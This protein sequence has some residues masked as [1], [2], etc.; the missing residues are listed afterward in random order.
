MRGRRYVVTVSGR[1]YAVGMCVTPLVY[2][3]NQEILKRDME[4]CE[5]RQNSKR[6]QSLIASER[7]IPNTR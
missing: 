5:D 3:G 4:V 6:E 2:G 1:R 7:T